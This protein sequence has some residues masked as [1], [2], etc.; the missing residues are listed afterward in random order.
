MELSLK[1]CAICTK[2]V[3][4]PCTLVKNKVVYYDTTTS[5]GYVYAIPSG[6]ENNNHIWC[7]LIDVTSLRGKTIFIKTADAYVA[8]QQ[9]VLLL[10]S[11][12]GFTLD[13]FDKVASNTPIEQTG[14]VETL[15]ILSESG[16]GQAFISIPSTA[17][18]LMFNYTDTFDLESPSFKI[19]CSEK[20]HFVNFYDDAPRA[21]LYG[22][23]SDNPAYNE[24][25][26]YLLRTSSLANNQT[27]KVKTADVYDSSQKR[28]VFLSE[29][30][31]DLTFDGFS[32]AAFS[33]RY[34]VYYSFILGTD[35][36]V[37]ET[38]IG[39]KILTL[40][41]GTKYILFNFNNTYG[42]STPEVS[43][44]DVP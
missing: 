12:T 29:L 25:S 1:N 38:G 9:R 22:I 2:K 13:T 24:L 28:V 27:F 41:T 37:T 8:N 7:Y 32:D 36:I 33:E 42:L 39:E 30:P 16:D 40:P 17:T 3:V 20:K 4:I 34:N 15:N 19:D 11:L 43:V 5:K 23:P 10:S 31:Y 14:I 18:Y 21:V 44:V 26:T 35:N 6:S